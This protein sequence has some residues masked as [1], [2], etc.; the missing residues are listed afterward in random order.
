[1]LL[2]GFGGFIRK[3][4]SGESP[5][6]QVSVEKLEE[7]FFVKSRGFQKAGDYGRVPDGLETDI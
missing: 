5:E 4:L 2:L 7:M 3:R 6:Y 1:M